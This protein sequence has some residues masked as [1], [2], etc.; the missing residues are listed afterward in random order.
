MFMIGRKGFFMLLTAMSI[1]LAAGA[2]FTLGGCD[3]GEDANE[4]GRQGPP[5]VSVV[6]AKAVTGDFLVYFQ[7]LGTVTPLNTVT[8]K[9]CVDG[10]LVRLHFTEGQHVTTGDLL[11]EIDPRPYQ[12][13]LAQAEGQLLRDKAL[14]K[15][16]RQ[17]LQRYK[18]LLP[19]DFA[20][21]HQVDAAEADVLQYEA[22]VKVDAGKIAAVKL[23]LEYCR[24][25]APVSGKLGLKL[26]TRATSCALP[27]AWG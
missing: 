11:A 21:P 2:V 8:V 15:N 7:S 16:A 24:V 5:A 26:W 23:Q 10:E 22:A 18:V 4:G 6:A 1:F 19:Q 14:L 9:S 17:D 13:E 25:T 3:G 27:T 20:T 12:A